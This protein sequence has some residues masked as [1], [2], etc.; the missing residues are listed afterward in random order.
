MNLLQDMI[1]SIEDPDQAV[2]QDVRE[3][4]NRIA[5]PLHSLGKLE[6][7]IVQIAGI[8]RTARI[9]IEKRAV[10][11]FCSDNG[12]VKEGVT[13][14]GQEVTAIVSENFKT[15]NT[16]ACAMARRANVDLFPFDFGICRD[17]TVC[18][19]HKIAYGTANMAE[20]PA[21]TRDM[22][23]KGLLEGMSIARGMHDKGYRILA[24]GEMGIGNTTT[25][26]AVSSVLLCEEPERM[27][28]RGAGLPDEGLARKIQ[29]IKKAIEVNR[30][31]P[32]DPVDVLSKVGGFDIAGMAGLVLGGALCRMP[33]VMDGFISLTASLIAVRICPKAVAYLIPSH[34]SKDPAAELLLREL[35]KDAMI[36]GGMFLGEGTG[37]IALFPLLDL[38]QAVYSEMSTF[39]DIAVEQYEDY[40]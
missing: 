1:G 20:G 12:V 21:M 33:V 37:A 15:G 3:R 35:K 36:H 25:S 31:D 39:D 18:A 7:L 29:V 22:A 32:K 34:V 8:Q 4:W 2:M 24:H 19:D 27:T 40:Q 14:T 17:T 11:E 28:G 38:A 26:S 10:I 16:C 30:P 23:L 5:K 9:D 6:D 13:Q